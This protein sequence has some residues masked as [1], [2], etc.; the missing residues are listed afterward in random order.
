M[1]KNI[2]KVVDAFIAGKAASGDSK[3]TCHTDGVTLY[4]YAM[5]LARRIDATTYAVVGDDAVWDKR[6]LSRTTRAQ[7]RAVLF[8]LELV[9]RPRVEDGFDRGS[10]VQTGFTVRRG[11]LPECVHTDCAQN[12][13][14]AYDCAHGVGRRGDKPS[15]M[16]VW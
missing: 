13:D 9:W 5:P 4:S 11:P 3:R 6:A 1:R 15:T 14:L 8:G 12:P 16:G 2:R 7:L 10:Y